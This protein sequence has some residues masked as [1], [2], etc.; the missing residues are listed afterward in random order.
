MSEYKNSYNLR[1]SAIFAALCCVFAGV[2]PC[3]AEPVADAQMAEVVVHVAENVRAVLPRDVMERLAEAPL[4]K[5]LRATKACADRAPVAAT[6]FPPVSSGKSGIDPGVRPEEIRKAGL[7]H[8]VII[9][10]PDSDALCRRV[11]G[12]T[13][14]IDPKAQRLVRYGVGIFRGDVG[15]VE[16]RWN[17]WLYSNA[18]DDNG[19]STLLVWISGTTPAG[20][21]RAFQAFLDGLDNG[22]VPCG[23][24]TQREI[25]TLLDR[26]PDVTPPPRVYCE[27]SGGF[28]YAGW[29]QPPA[30]EMR[31]YQEVGGVEPVNLWRVKFLQEGSLAGAEGTVWLKGPALMAWGNARTIVRFADAEMARAAWAG[32]RARSGGAAVSASGMVDAFSVPMPVDGMSPRSPGRILY[33]LRGNELIATSLPDDAD[34]SLF[35]KSNP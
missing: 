31:A 21:A 26:E 14:G 9:G 32:V 25:R 34:G 19:Y 3:V 11:G 5:A 1:F 12:F 35:P 8:Q 28:V 15:I 18:F 2:M 20:V 30:Q 10:L 7:R 17:P 27:A 24:R 4:L 29:N 6:E 22:V 13:F 23:A 33:A 16:T